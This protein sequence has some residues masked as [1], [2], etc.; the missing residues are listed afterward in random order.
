MREYRFIVEMEDGRCYGVSAFNFR[1]AEILVKAWC[2]KN[3]LD[4]N[5][6]ITTGEEPNLAPR[7]YVGIGNKRFELEWQMATKT[8]LVA[9][10]G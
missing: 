1:E 5:V 6:D 8:S 4:T 10:H 2:I 9:V 3:G 7:S